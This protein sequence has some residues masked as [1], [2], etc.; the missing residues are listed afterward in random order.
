M[1]EG[2]E[3]SV[4]IEVRN[5]GFKKHEGVIESSEFDKNEIKVDIWI[6]WIKG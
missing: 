3:A 4:M 2:Y 1:T 6:V 5:K